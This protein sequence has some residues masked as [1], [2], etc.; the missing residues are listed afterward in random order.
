MTLPNYIAYIGC[1]SKLDGGIHVLNVNPETGE[2][3][4]VRIVRGIADP[5][6]VIVNKACTRLYAGICKIAGKTDVGGA[7][8]YKIVGDD[9]VFSSWQPSGGTKPCHV[10]LDNDE[11]ALFASNY[12]EGT[13]AYFKLDANG[14]ILPPSKQ[15]VHEGHGPNPKRQTSPHIHFASTTPDNRLVYF[16]DLGIDTVKAYNFDDGKGDLSPVPQADI[17][18]APGAGPRH[19]HFAQN[20]KYAYVINEVDSTISAYMK[21]GISYK[22]FQTC[23][24]LPPNYPKAEENT[25][26]AIKMTA[27]GTRLLCSNRGYDSIAVFDVNQANGQLTLLAINPTM[28]RGPRDFSFLPGDNFVLVAHQYSDNVICFK[29]DHETGAFAPVGGQVLVPQGVCVQIGAPVM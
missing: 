6:Y 17:H 2:F 19:L 4:R 15:F 13:G 10:A 7:A 20:G 16:V 24:L 28:G 11:K 9:L 14:D 18:T 27:D 25:A 21:N 1:Y 3:R 29:F 5:T 12:S 26:A 8:C 23:S 22:H